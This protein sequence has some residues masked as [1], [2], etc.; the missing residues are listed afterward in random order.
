MVQNSHTTAEVLAVLDGDLSPRH[1]AA[2]GKGKSP[3]GEVGRAAQA[4]PRRPGRA[5]RASRNL[6]CQGSKRR[7]FHAQQYLDLLPCKR[8]TSVL[9]QASSCKACW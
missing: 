5:G 9:C 6:I 7:C 1:A 4:A 3:A 2:M 8:R